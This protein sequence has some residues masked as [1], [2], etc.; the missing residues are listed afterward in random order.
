MK[1]RTAIQSIIVT[2]AGLAILP[3]CNF[4]Q[5]PLKVYKNI[6]LDRGQRVI[7]SQLSEAILPKVGL[8]QFTTPESRVDFILTM[9]NDCSPKEEIDQYVAGLID[10]QAYLTEKYNQSFTDLQ[11]AQLTEMMTQLTTSEEVPASIQSFFNKTNSLTQ[12]HFRSSEYYMKNY[13]DFEFAPRRY[14]GCLAV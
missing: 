3:S 11:P 6:P 14:E 5:E 1:R 12:Q 2:T 4:F 13:L 8:E 7:L 10:F 9:L